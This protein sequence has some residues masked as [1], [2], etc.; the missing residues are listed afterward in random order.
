[1]RVAIEAK[2]I[3]GQTCHIEPRGGAGKKQEKQLNGMAVLVCTAKALRSSSEWNFGE[4]C[5]NAE[6]P[7]GLHARLSY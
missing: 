7:F 5:S 3:S 1:L 6:Q 2:P 4:G